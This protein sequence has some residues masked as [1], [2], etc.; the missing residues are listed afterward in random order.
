MFVC[1]WANYIV[2]QY[3]IDHINKQVPLS[4]LGRNF[5]YILYINGGVFIKE[6]ECILSACN[7]E[8]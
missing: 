8:V 4:L 1:V 7:G 2:R 6:K 3:Q 5:N